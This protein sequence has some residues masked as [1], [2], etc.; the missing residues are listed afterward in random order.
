MGF[1]LKQIG[2]NGCLMKGET[3]NV[4]TVF[5]FCFLGYFVALPNQN[6]AIQRTEFRTEVLHRA[7]HS[8]KP[9][10]FDEQDHLVIDVIE[11]T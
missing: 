11:V 7:W 2:M 1:E 10:I 6:A 3:E 5:Y 4:C 9:S 8:L